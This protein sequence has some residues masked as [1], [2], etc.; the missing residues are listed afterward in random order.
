MKRKKSLISL[1]NKER[2]RF[3]LERNRCQCLLSKKGQKNFSR[4]REKEKGTLFWMGKRASALYLSEKE[5]E[6][7]AFMPWQSPAKE[8]IRLPPRGAGEKSLFSKVTYWE[9]TS[10]E[11]RGG[12]IT[13]LQSMGEERCLFPSWEYSERPMGHS[14]YKKGKRKGVANFKKKGKGDSRYIPNQIE[15]SVAKADTPEIYLILAERERGNW[16]GRRKKRLPV[17]REGIDSSEARLQ[18]EENVKMRAL[19]NGRGNP[20]VTISGKEWEGKGSQVPKEGKERLNREFCRSWKREKN[21]ATINQGEEATLSSI[22]GGKHV[23]PYLSRGERKKREQSLSSPSI[24]WR[25][26]RGKE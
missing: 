1:T 15:R 3:Y 4:E 9:R 20:T 13:T 26:G 8:E 21:I 18:R 24:D 16:K 10:N 17:Y 2:R 11:D 5:Q 14:R 6:N 23:R 12:A 25:E 7:C 22:T 19:C